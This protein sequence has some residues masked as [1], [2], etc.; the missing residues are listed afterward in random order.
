MSQ[1]TICDGCGEDTHYEMFVRLDLER[2]RT[3][4][5][6]QPG[7]GVKRQLLLLFGDN[8]V[9]MDLCVA[10]QARARSMLSEVFPE[11][12]RTR[13]SWWRAMGG[14]IPSSPSDP[15]PGL[16]IRK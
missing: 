12:A 6:G 16:P 1:R 3:A 2:P 7:D 15:V 10:C 13:E 11:M 9:T 14:E 8:V 5:L 4:S